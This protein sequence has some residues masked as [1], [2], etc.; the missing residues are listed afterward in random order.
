MTR[1][2]RSGRPVSWLIILI[3]LGL[4]GALRA[5]GFQGLYQGT[6]R[7]ATVQAGGALRFAVDETGRVIGGF[8]SAFPN[9]T[10]SGQVD[11]N[12]RIAIHFKRSGRSEI[13]FT[14]SVSKDLK[15]SG[16]FVAKL[17]Q[18]TH[19]GTWEAQGDSPVQK[20]AAA[21]TD[22]RIL[23]PKRGVRDQAG[24][25]GAAV[26]PDH[27]AEPVRFLWSPEP[28]SGQG[29]ARVQYRW[30]ETGEKKITVRASNLDGA[31]AAMAEHRVVISETP[32]S[33]YWPHAAPD[34]A[35]ETKPPE[36]LGWDARKLQAAVDYAFGLGGREERHRT[37]SFLVIVDGYIVAERYAKGLNR[38]FVRTIASA[39]KSITACLVGI[40][41]DKGL[42]DIHDD[43]AL[44][45]P[46]L[47]FLKASGDRVWHHLTMTSG[48]TGEGRSGGTVD[49]FQYRPGTHWRYNTDAY[50]MLYPVI[51][52]AGRKEAG[53][54]R[55]DVLQISNDWLF[56][57]IGVE[58]VDY[59]RVPE[60]PHNPTGV[61]TPIMTARG[62]ARF[63]LLVLRNGHWDGERIISP[64][65]LNAAI[66]SSQ[67]LNP[68]YG[69]L[70]WL[71]GRNKLIQ[72]VGKAITPSWRYPDAPPDA[73]GCHG[74][75][76][77]HIVI[78]PSLKTVVVRQ[79]DQPRIEAENRDDA[80]LN[81]LLKRLMAAA[82]NTVTVKTSAG[83]GGTIA[84]S[85]EVQVVQGLNQKFW[86]IPAPGYRL[87]DLRLDGDSVGPVSEYLLKDVKTAHDI[88]AVFAP[89][90]RTRPHL[91]ETVPADRAEN[92][93]QQDPV[94][95]F[96][97]EAMD[98]AS[99]ESAFTVTDLAGRPVSGTVTCN[100]ARTRATFQPNQPLAAGTVYA[101]AVT[102][103]ARDAAGNPLAADRLWIFTT[104]QPTP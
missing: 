84:P 93:P 22:V 47:K 40:A 23:G 55:R 50:H 30:S 86:A 85:G 90:D 76:G 78:I 15:A 98:P 54:G 13:N 20:P 38:D 103:L 96:F 83:E 99:L 25:W 8:L 101:A 9:I 51:E 27:A 68:S 34:H 64:A 104:E 31:A 14:G 49:R 61:A 2:S 56:E 36:T 16:A 79:G 7:A 43:M 33:E 72:P 5:E 42:L 28:E 57:P 92:W 91:Q 95:A 41:Q 97:S 62:M 6:W 39:G 82:P 44:Y 45:F 17:P 75:G 69:Y 74:A 71:N 11:P 100:K 53:R 48:L 60:K 59:R 63:G 94:I 21:V 52:Q 32:P 81:Q 37:D 102:S 3:L 1:K 87:A 58:K 35:W 67:V 80:F 65:F 10:G 19:Q 29:R 18:A 4:P 73:F 46:E 88:E 66:S 70:F 26:S 24:I 89:G 77:Q 12:G